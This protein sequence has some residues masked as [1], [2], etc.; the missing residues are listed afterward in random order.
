MSVPT[1][2]NYSVRKRMK[3]LSVEINVYDIYDFLLAF[4]LPAWVQFFWSTGY[5]SI[6][7]LNRFIVC[8]KDAWKKSAAKCVQDATIKI[9]YK[10]IISKINFAV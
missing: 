7:L 8:I 3:I 6:K 4:A 5:S 1:L 9:K 10:P 2:L